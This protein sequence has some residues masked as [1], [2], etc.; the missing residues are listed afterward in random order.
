MNAIENYECRVFVTD[1]DKMRYD[2][3]TALL[4]EASEY[5]AAHK[6]IKALWDVRL[7]FSEVLHWDVTV[8]RK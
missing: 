1:K 6:A 8:N 2:M 7:D 5:K 3:G 4:E